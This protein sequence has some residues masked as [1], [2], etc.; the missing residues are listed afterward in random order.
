MVHCL[1]KGF[2]HGKIIGL[3]QG[4]PLC[5]AANAFQRGGV[6]GKSRGGQQGAA[7]LER[8]HQPVDQ[9]RRPIAAQDP[10][11]RQLFRLAECRAQLPAKGVRIAVRSG[12]CRNDGIRHALGQA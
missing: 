6:L 4:F 10:R 9:I 1:H 7:G 12:Q 5:F 2:R 3:M 11:L 8:P